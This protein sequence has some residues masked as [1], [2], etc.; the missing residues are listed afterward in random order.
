MRAYILVT[1][2]IFALLT[3]LHLWR[4]FADWSGF[5]S[6]LWTLLAT[7]ALCGGLAYWAWRLFGE[8]SRQE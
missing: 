3:L 8:L 6:G 7:M 2:L 1:G 4:I 5:D